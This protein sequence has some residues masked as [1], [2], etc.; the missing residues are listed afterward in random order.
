MNEIPRPFDLI[1]SNN[2]PEKQFIKLHGQELFDKLKDEA[3]VLDRGRCSACGHEPPKDRKKDFLYYHIYEYDK[4]QP[5]NTKGTTL[6]KMCHMTQ[7]IES[8]IKKKWV[9]LVNSIYDQNNII[10][11]T[12]GNQIYQNINSRAIVQ[13]RKTPEQFLSEIYSGEARFTTT[14]KV[15]FT[16]NFNI[17]DF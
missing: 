4:K 15:V 12:R 13:L 2:V 5:E 10:R 17:D 11:L 9:L 6:C 16:Q 14:L 3:F 8:A 7:H 1:V